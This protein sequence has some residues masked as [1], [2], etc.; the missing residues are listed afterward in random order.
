MGKGLSVG[1]RGLAADDAARRNDAWDSPFQPLLVCPSDEQDTR[2][3]KRLVRKKKRR[4][5]NATAGA[6]ATGQRG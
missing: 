4:G 2:D 5:P 3:D 1:R 6:G